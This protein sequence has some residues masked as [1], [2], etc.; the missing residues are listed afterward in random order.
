MHVA[1]DDAIQQGRFFAKY[2]GGEFGGRIEYISLDRGPLPPTEHFAFGGR[3]SRLSRRAGA[4]AGRSCVFLARQPAASDQMQ[5]L[6]VYYAAR[7]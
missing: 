6:P 3:F 1:L 2:A 5:Y 7:H 4:E